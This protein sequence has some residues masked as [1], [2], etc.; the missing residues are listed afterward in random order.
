MVEILLASCERCS[1]GDIELN[2]F[3]K[4]LSCI[5]CGHVTY[6]DN[7]NHH[8]EV[9]L[10]IIKQIFS[11]KEK[12]TIIQSLTEVRDRTLGNAR[13]SKYESTKSINTAQAEFLTNLIDRI[14]DMKGGDA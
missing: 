11:L 4:E 1:V 10:P 3:T 13:R 8:K 12:Q 9:P 7:S 6:P 5:Q 2:P 14:R